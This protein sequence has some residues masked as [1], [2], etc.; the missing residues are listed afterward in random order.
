VDKYT[1]GVKAASTTNTVP[2]GMLRL[3]IAG[4]NISGVSGRRR[5]TPCSSTTRT[6]SVGTEA[7]EL[8]RGGC[9]A[10]RTSSI[11]LR[12]RVGP[13]PAA[14]PLS[15]KCCPARRRSDS[16]GLLPNLPEA[17]IPRAEP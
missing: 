12:M 2:N 17:S 9:A 1:P 8:A 16:A 4:N 6:N 5:K 14:V 15:M 11:S 7:Q 3:I 13:K 10:A